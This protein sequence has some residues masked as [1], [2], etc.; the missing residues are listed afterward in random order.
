MVT[1][2]A[3]DTA[4]NRPRLTSVPNPSEL[5]DDDTPE[6][7]LT[8]TPH[9]ADP[10]RDYL[11]LIGRTPL[12][13]AAQEVSLAK[14]IE[15]GVLAQERL[16][17]AGGSQTE[18]SGRLVRE[19]AWIAADGL[20]AKNHLVEANLRLVVSITKKM[21]GRGLPLL[22]L[23]QEGNLGLVKATEK[24]DHTRGYK[25]STYATWWIRQAAQRALADQSRT[26]RVPAGV[27]ERLAALRRHTLQLE[28]DLGRPATTQELAEAMDLSIDKVEALHGV[29]RTPISLQS[30]LSEGGGE[31]GDLI[32]DTFTPSPQDVVA[33]RILGVELNHVLRLLNSRQSEVLRLRY[34]LVDGVPRTVAE[35]SDMW[36]ISRERVRQMELRSLRRLRAHGRIDPMRS[37]LA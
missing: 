33:A 14:R 25:F 12:L 21:A 24:Y 35:V 31:F 22:D 32:E 1:T 11:R 27:A 2:P 37:Y 6:P 18:P 30:P 3:S 8:S 17:T 9:S 7:V 15:A 28:I 5:D 26:I 20:R 4:L 29:G 13:T 36:G 23:I 10:V 16:D 34:G 19:L